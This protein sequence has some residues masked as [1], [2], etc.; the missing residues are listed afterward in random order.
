VVTTDPREAGLRKVLNYGHTLGHA[1]ESYFLA[2][3]DKEKLTHGAAI[4]VGMITEAYLSHKVLGFPMDQVA[5]IKEKLLAIYPKIAIT[6]VDYQEILALLV[7]DKK[8]VDGQVNFVL[9]SAYA[10]FTLDCKVET[11]LLSAAL[12]Y[13]IA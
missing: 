9:L 3:S 7:H 8:N 4:A 1:I 10:T 13:Y 11:S 5:F 12:D 2:S 6:S